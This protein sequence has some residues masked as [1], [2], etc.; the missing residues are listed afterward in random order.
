MKKL[1]LLF[2]ILFFSLSLIVSCSNNV[3][4]EM[5]KEAENNVPYASV[6]ELDALAKS[7]ANVV[8]YQVARTLGLI[9][10]Q[11]FLESCS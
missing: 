5:N 9:E 7:D 4:D 2:S 1:I 11:N 10:M 8:N 6:E 3:F